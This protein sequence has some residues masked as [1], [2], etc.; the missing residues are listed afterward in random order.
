[1]GT[2]VWAQQGPP[3]IVATIESPRTSQVPSKIAEGSAQ[4]PGLEKVLP[5]FRS[6]VGAHDATLRKIQTL[7][8]GIDFRASADGGRTWKSLETYKVWKSGPRERIHKT[9]HHVYSPAGGFE[10]IMPPG[11]EKDVLFAPDGVRTLDRYDTANAPKEP[12][13]IQSRNSIVGTIQPAQAF[14][15]EGYKS[16]LAADYLLLTL[17]DVIYSLHDLCE[18]E[19]NT[20]SKPVERRDAQGNVLWDLALKAPR[21]LTL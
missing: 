12:V 1:M 11:G 15:V 4:N 9:T 17:P 19:I 8:C 16:G 14:A 10:V 3:A 2:V 20:A 13:T 21:A 7:K 18:A 5:Q 6:V